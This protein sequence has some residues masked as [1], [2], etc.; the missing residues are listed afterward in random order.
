MWE[1]LLDNKY[2]QYMN[3]MVENFRWV[4]RRSCC[5][6][7]ILDQCEDVWRQNHAFQIRCPTRVAF[8]ALAISSTPKWMSLSGDRSIACVFVQLPC[9]F[10]TTDTRILTTKRGIWWRNCLSRDHKSS[11]MLVYIGSYPGVRG[12]LT[13]LPLYKH[14]TTGHWHAVL[15]L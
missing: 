11:D 15:T 10:R 9:R 5:L 6:L 8:Q 13:R 2:T 14:G 1:Q 7:Q 4:L 12:V 3:F